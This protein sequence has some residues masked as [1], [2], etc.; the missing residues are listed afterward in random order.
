MRAHKKT[1]MLLACLVLLCPA[2]AKKADSTPPQVVSHY[3][4]KCYEPLAYLEQR[5]KR[6]GTG[7]ALGA[8]QGGVI[9]GISAVIIGYSPFQ[10]LSNID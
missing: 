4:P 7:I 3:Y 2:C 10:Y 6:A 8:A 9:T 1:A 5:G